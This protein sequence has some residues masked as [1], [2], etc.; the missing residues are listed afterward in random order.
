MA[1][2]KTK[3]I[4]GAVRSQFEKYEIEEIHREALKN[5]PYNP[6]VISAKAKKALKMNLEKVGL[7]APIIWNRR[8]GNIVSGHQRINALDALEKSYDYLVKV[9]VV[10][11]DE[12]TEKEQNIFM[13][14]PE[15]QGDF[16]LEGLE[17]MIKDA[18][19][20]VEEMGFD[21][22]D[23]M[24]F[25]GESALSNDEL[26]DMSNKLHEMRD[27]FDKI[28]ANSDNRDNIDYFLVVIFK[29]H[30]GRKAFTDVI[31]VR[32]FRYLDGKIL[33]EAIKKTS[34]EVL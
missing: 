5:A 24:N 23:I 29:D 6:R 31:G 21:Q 19:L 16:D 20:N 7:L 14:N 1:N 13:N 10:D 28:K 4:I 17:S 33:M 34:E 25:F 32:D 12:K 22:G 27:G 3:T 8:T 15:V 11:L 18:N 30:E 2:K 26:A 9:A